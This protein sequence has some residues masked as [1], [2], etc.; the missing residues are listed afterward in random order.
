MSQPF[1][2]EIE[3]FAFNFAPRG[4]LQCNGQ[5]LPIQQ[6]TALFSL[7]GTTYGGNGIQTFALPNLQSQITNGWGAGNQLGEVSGQQAHTLLLAET[8][9][10]TH[11]LN[12]A[13]VPD[14]TTN[15]FHPSATTGLASSIAKQ[16]GTNPVM[17]LYVADP[18]PNVGMA[19]QEIGPSNGGNQAHPNIMPYL[20][21]NYCIA[22]SGIF[23]SRG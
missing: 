3:A 13:V 21:I 16:G 20:T 22:M 15:T 18:A 14:P 17:N 5:I 4:W 19:A 12:A 23:P 8:P 10:H 1:L 9:Q 2:G 6:Y 7:L 11:A